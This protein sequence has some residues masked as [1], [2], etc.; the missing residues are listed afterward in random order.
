MHRNLLTFVS[1][2][3]LNLSSVSSTCLLQFSRG[4]TLLSS[5]MCSDWRGRGSGSRSGLHWQNTWLFVE[6]LAV[7]S[8]KRVTLQFR[9]IYPLGRPGSQ[10]EEIQ[11]QSWQTW[12]AGA[13]TYF[14]MSTELR[15]LNRSVPAMLHCLISY[16]IPTSPFTDF[17]FS[18]C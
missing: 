16:L 11:M 10:Y 14:G 18:L 9:S 7:A 8:V 2:H 17:F 13:V 6:T 1:L 12:F 3:W 15:R 4:A 5:V